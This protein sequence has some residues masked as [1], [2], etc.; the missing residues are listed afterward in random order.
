MSTFN[1]QDDGLQDIIGDILKGE[2]QLP[3]F[4][5]GWV[6]DDEH[7]RSLLVSVA[8]SFPIGAVMTLETGG[9]IH[10]K[11]RP[12]ENVILKNP[13]EPKFLILDGQQRLT[14]L[15]QVLGLK[16][17]VKTFDHKKNKVEKYYYIDINKFLVGIDLDEAIYSVG[18]DKKITSDFGRKVELDLSTRE[19][20]VDAFQFPCNEIFNPNEWRKASF[21]K[22]KFDEFNEFDESVLKAFEHY[23]IPVINLLQQ[24]SKEA[25]CLVFEKVNTGGV[26]LS[27][28]ELIT[29]TFAADSYNLR[30]DWFGDP[31][32]ESP[33]RLDRLVKD[34]LL[35]DI[36]PTDF[37]QALTLLYSYD[38]NIRAKKEGKTGTKLPGISCKRK[39]MLN[40][41]LKDYKLWEDKL[42][43]A[44]IETAKFL[45]KECFQESK[46]IPYN[47]QLIPLAAILVHLKGRWLEPKIN[48]KLSRWFW[49]GVMGELYGS[50]TENRFA[51]D[52][53]D[54][55]AW[56]DDDNKIPRTVFDASF[57]PER[58]ETLRTRNSAAY[59]GLHILVLRNG[60]KDF[61]FKADVN[62]I[63]R[64]GESLDIHHLFPKKWCIENKIH[65][66]VY[67]SAVNK[68]PISSKANRKIGGD[69]PSLYLTRI[70]DDEQALM[71]DRQMDSILET[72]LID[73]GSFRNDD[74]VEFMQ[75]RAI[76]LTKIIYEAMGKMDSFPN[77]ISLFGYGDT[78]KKVKRILDKIESGEADNVEF[79][80]TFQY[81]L[82]TNDYDKALKQVV[83]KSIAAMSNANGGLLI[84]GV[85]DNGEILGLGEDY[86]LLD[87]PNKD[88][89]ELKLRETINNTF[90][91]DFCASQL[92]VDFPIIHSKEICCID[93]KRGKKPLYIKVTSKNGQTDDK[94]YLRIGNSSQLLDTKEIA[95]Y[96][97][98][99]FKRVTK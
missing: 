53:E 46:D 85:A 37:I 92:S 63:E 28:F 68:T 33:G 76:E 72:H 18:P 43:M 90:G 42:E 44:F 49:C 13:R 45:R 24:T 57:N 31:N 62:G 12:I 88:K 22:G 54:V 82:N 15:T 95:S 77:R 86:S 66:N 21:K 17:S 73:P 19:K 40:L 61:F 51:N 20:E 89:F 64:L 60:A 34:N 74:F 36:Q 78:S 4:Q 1:R 29:A 35:K 91:K 41:E 47:T 94:F 7:V 27:V 71:N 97:Q 10:F 2:H 23:K 67:D 55:L 38:L 87:N 25:V 50:A 30:E 69:S 8:K 93:I 39:T 58:L 5:R 3:D 79:K 83:L 56:I 75:K 81:N 70:Q 84:I 32:S 65:R 14:S 11:A 80:S 98:D 96:C 9:D 59:K 99:R 26:S 16:D 52:I 6:W 48:N